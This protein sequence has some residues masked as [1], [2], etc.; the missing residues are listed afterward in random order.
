MEEGNENNN[1]VEDDGGEI[2]I[3]TKKKKT[4]TTTTT[5]SPRKRTDTF[6][7]FSDEENG[8][9]FQ[10][11]MDERNDT[12]RIYEE[13]TKNDYS[14][15]GR[16]CWRAY[17]VK[18]GSPADNIRA[19]KPYRLAAVWAVTKGRYLRAGKRDKLKANL[20]SIAGKRGQ[21]H[22]HRC[23][24]D[25]CCNPGHIVV[26]SRTDNE[27]DKH[28]HYFLNHE[29]AEVRERFLKAFPDLMKHQHVW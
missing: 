20:P 13:I 28:F 29:D 16:T 21:H 24:N 12:Y 8:D 3:I 26:G 25:W 7:S 17:S 19:T 1:S 4:T 27:V 9:F 10:A 6:W 18:T 5:K 2:I 11:I 22:R 14:G 23:G 15:K